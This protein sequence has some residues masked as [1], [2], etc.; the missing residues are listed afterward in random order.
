MTELTTYE[1]A[2]ALAARTGCDP[3]TAARALREGPDAIRTTLLRERLSRAM[4]EMG[5]ASRLGA[6][7]GD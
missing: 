2:L 7:I 5:I 6:R 3:R 4:G 1:L